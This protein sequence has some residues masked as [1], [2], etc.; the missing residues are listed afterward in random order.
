[1][2]RPAQLCFHIQTRPERRAEP[3]RHGR[4]RQDADPRT[5]RWGGSCNADVR[6]CRNVDVPRAITMRKERW[7]VGGILGYS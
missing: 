1:M 2:A 7:F 5:S 6:T 3:R 4:G